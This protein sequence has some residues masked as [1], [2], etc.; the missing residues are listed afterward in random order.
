MENPPDKEH[1]QGGP[2]QEILDLCQEDAD[3]PGVT[4]CIFL[5]DITRSLTFPLLVL[6]ATIRCRD[7]KD[8]LQLMGQEFDRWSKAFSWFPASKLS[9]NTVTK[10]DICHGGSLHL[11]FGEIASE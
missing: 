1:P 2:A 3:R 10:S 6:N 7:L 4:V 5:A 8:S 9:S 11:A